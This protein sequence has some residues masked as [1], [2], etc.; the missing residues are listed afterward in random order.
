MKFSPLY[1]LLLITATSCSTVEVIGI[2][3]EKPAQITLP[4]CI[5]NITI[6]NNAITQPDS[7]NHTI[8]KSFSTME[9]AIP[10]DSINTVL[11]QALAQF[12]DEKQFYNQVIAYD[13][14]LRE[15]GF[16]LTE[17]AIGQD[18]IRRIVGE[19]NADA[20]ISLDR[21]IAQ[22]TITERYNSWIDYS[23]EVT[24]QAKFR[25]YDA[26]GSTIGQPVL[27]QDTLYW[28]LDY[29]DSWLSTM[30]EAL[31]Q[32]AIYTA[33]K[34]TSMFIPYWRRQN[35]WIYTGGGKDMREAVQNAMTNN[36]KEAALLWGEL[37]G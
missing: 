14:P 1:C 6:V 3:V 36:W 27:F 25:I 32:S 30:K 29:P 7:I 26:D 31:K 20:I 21:F 4:T 11:T 19:T 16:F 10:A 35:R 13:R 5:Q 28:N 22:A 2:D 23:M 34:M 24:M 18:S 8:K 17:Q 37:Y 33:D 9:A 12:M 15:S